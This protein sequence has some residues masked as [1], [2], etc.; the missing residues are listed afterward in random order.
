MAAVKNRVDIFVRAKDQATKVLRGVK[1]GLDAIPGPIKSIGGAYLTWQAGTKAIEAT[2]GAAAKQEEIF[3]RLSN[4][5]A[6]TGQ[7]YER[8]EGKIQNFLAQ[9]QE[10]TIYGDTDMAVVLQ[11][12]TTLT[13]KFG[14]ATLEASQIAADMAASGLFNLETATRYVGMAMGGNVEML[15]RYIP[16]MKASAGI[17]KANMTASQK[18]AVAQDV[19]R[20]KF[21]GMAAGELNTYNGRMKQLKNYI[22]DAGEAIGMILLPALTSMAKALVSIVAPLAKFIEFL[23][24]DN[25]TNAAQQMG[26]LNENL[27]KFKGNVVVMA[28]IAEA[29]EDYKEKVAVLTGKLEEGAAKQEVYTSMAELFYDTQYDGITG[30]TARMDALDQVTKDYNETIETIITTSEKERG[31]TIAKIDVERLFREERK[32]ANEAETEMIRLTAEE[33][34]TLEQE[35]IELRQESLEIELMSEEERFNHFT[36]LRAQ[37]MI[38]SKK[39][40]VEEAAAYVKAQQKKMGA[41]KLFESGA[42]IVFD[43]LENS[44]IESMETGQLQLRTVFSGMAKDFMKLFITEILKSVKLALV[45]KLISLLKIFDRYENDRMAMKVGE[46]YASFFVRGIENIWGRTDFAGM[47]PAFA[48]NIGM[49]PGPAAPIGRSVTVQVNID[50]M[51]GTQDFIDTVVVPGVERAVRR[52]ESSIVLAA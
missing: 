26:L 10:T 36:N 31:A 43:R 23:G 48:G 46:D 27:E 33:L 6:I 49:A 42:G 29:T 12:L 14:D 37:E 8:T 45:M 15:G 9:M 21:G 24:S 22:G 28:Q 1:K 25:I 39:Y 3:N 32:L 50:T 52:D 11:Q 44:L 20:E 30:V 47:A 13:G 18:W 41:V 17:I 19:L 38:T 35:R 51:I 40:S 16:E 4:A 7:S 34:R 2:I 5:I